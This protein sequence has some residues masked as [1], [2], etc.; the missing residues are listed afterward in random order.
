MT[1]TVLTYLDSYCERAGAVGLFAEPLNLLTNVLFLVAAGVALR[2]LKQ[3]P[4]QGRR[5][6]LWL[7]VGLLASIGVG[8]GLWHAQPNGATLL[9]DVVPIT[10]FINLYIVAAL[11]RLFGL[12]WW[13]VGG[14]WALYFGVGMWAQTHLPPELLNGTIM[15]IPTYG[16]LVVLT[17][18][19][20]RHAPGQGRA[21]AVALLVWSASLALRTLDRDIC[22]DLGI[23]AHFLW[24][25]LNAWVLWRLLMV[26]IRGR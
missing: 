19:L 10:L 5:L 1:E 20:L 21:F 25:T 7:L 12:G 2:A 9:M 13:K 23:G 18:A 6:D 4:V 26:L 17:L 8:S 11:R 24:H 15:Y 14:F 16:A 3:A 22:P